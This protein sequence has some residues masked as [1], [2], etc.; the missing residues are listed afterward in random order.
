MLLRLVVVVV[1]VSL[2]LLLLQVSCVVCLGNMLLQCCCWGR[3]YVKI[4]EAKQT[5]RPPIHRELDTEHPGG[6][7][8]A[9]IQPRSSPVVFRENNDIRL[10]VARL[11]VLRST[12]S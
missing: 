8:C 11:T 3:W 6:V 9:S 5:S 1:G 4:R 10:R 12:T 2:L 7:D